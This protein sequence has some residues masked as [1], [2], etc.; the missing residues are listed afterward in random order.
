MILRTQQR[1]DRKGY[2]LMEVLL[3][4]AIFGTAVTSIVIALH[5]TGEVSHTIQTESIAQQHLKNLMVEVLT[6]PTP[7][8]SFERDEIRDLENGF[9]ARIQIT[10][11]NQINQNENELTDLYDVKITITW[12]DDSGS[13]STTANCVHYYPLH[14]R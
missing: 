4:F 7:K 13:E 5:K 14:Q 9:T 8:D 6:I 1:K 12:E 11:S 10:P 2:V 3:A